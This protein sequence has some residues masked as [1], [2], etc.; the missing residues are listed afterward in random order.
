MEL[1]RRPAVAAFW[2]TAIAVAV[3]AA[4]LWA[5]HE[6]S[7]QEIEARI[8]RESNPV[9]KAKL[10]I[11]LGSLKLEKAGQAYARDDTEAGA[12]LLDA[13]KVWMQQAWALL[14][15]SGRDA[16]HKPQG[17][18]DLD[19]ALREGAR[20]LDDLQRGVPSAERGAIQHAAKELDAVH[21]RVLSAL[22]PGDQMTDS[23]A[24]AAP[25]KANTPPPSGLRSGEPQP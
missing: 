2:V 14:E 19:I 24:R 25:A 12:K 5:R 9:K 3:A 4:N 16:V 17:F 11:E 15:A 18:K 21:Q 20:K 22:F 7:E 1:V 8:E 6:E 10:E 23:A 13:C